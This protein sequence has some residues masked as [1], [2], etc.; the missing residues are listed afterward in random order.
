MKLSSTRKVVWALVV[1]LF[2]LFIAELPLGLH[3]DSSSIVEASKVDYHT[4]SNLN[5]RSGASTKHKI[6][7]TIPK[8]KKVDYLSKSGSWFKVKYNGKT[9]FVSSSYVKKAAVP[10]PSKTKTPAAKAAT[11]NKVEYQTTTN[12]NLRAGASTKHKVL[13][14][15]PKGRKVD[16]VSKSGTWFKVKYSGKTGF[17]SS[18]YV[19]NVTAAAPSKAKAQPAPTK[20]APTPKGE[21]QTTS[22][23]NMRAGGSTKHKILLTIPKGKKVEYVSATGSWFQIKYSGKTGFVSSKYLTKVNAAAKPAPE[24]KPT[25][26]NGVLLVNKAHGLPSHYAPGENKEARAAF[27]QMA[28][29]SNKDGIKLTAF[30]TYR[31]YDYQKTLYTN[32]VKK[33]GQAAADRYSAKPGHSEH[34]TGLAFDISQTGAKNP[35]AESKATKWMETNAHTY[36]FIVRYPKGKEHITGYMY[37]PWHLRYLGVDLATKVYNSGKTLEEYL[38]VK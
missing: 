33:D 34:Q 29:A 11:P 5:L 10:A 28:A 1:I 16:Y 7:L 9:G 25:H 3:S 32:Y 24:V 14:T 30:S 37:E 13:L 19:K 31:S 27:N 20:T 21:Y 2:S 26:I 17:V 18:S 36:G 38:G 6:L 8:G 12:L 15:I 35:F 4:T 22:N 23:L